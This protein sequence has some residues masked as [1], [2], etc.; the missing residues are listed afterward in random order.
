M[1]RR[2]DRADLATDF[3]AYTPEEVGRLRGRPLRVEA[4]TVRRALLAR[5]DKSA[6]ADRF[7]QA[8]KLAQP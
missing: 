6:Q 7:M 2:F 5:V 4:S 8:G 3:V 1:L